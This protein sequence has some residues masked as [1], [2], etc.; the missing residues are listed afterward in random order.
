M[1]GTSADDGPSVLD[2]LVDV[3]LE[4][5]DAWR[6]ALL[7]RDCSADAP[8][9]QWRDQSEDTA[10][11]ARDL[12]MQYVEDSGILSRPKP[13]P[14]TSACLPARIGSTPRVQTGR[15]G[16]G[17]CTPHHSLQPAQCWRAP[18]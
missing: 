7:E 10:I 8:W 11:T 17:G 9:Q 4:L 14:S 18:R 15:R 13:S 5:R 1:S 6:A 2:G 16:A 3:Y 12:L